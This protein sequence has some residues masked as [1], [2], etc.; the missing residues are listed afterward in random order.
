MFPLFV[1]L[2]DYL[3]QISCGQFLLYSVLYAFASIL[4]ESIGANKISN[5]APPKAHLLPRE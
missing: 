3:R 5:H 2:A 4:C 1:I